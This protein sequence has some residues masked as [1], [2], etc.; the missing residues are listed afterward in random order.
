[1][2]LF[3]DD[4]FTAKAKENGKPRVWHFQVQ[5]LLCEVKGVLGFTQDLRAFGEN[6][7]LVEYGNH[8]RVDLSNLKEKSRFWRRLERSYGAKAG[9]W[10]NGRRS[11]IF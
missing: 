4:R 7:E 2:E 8:G 3:Q 1:M 6:S 10:I 5:G 11:K 9:V